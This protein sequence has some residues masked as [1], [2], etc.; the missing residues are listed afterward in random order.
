MSTILLKLAPLFLTPI[1]GFL[2]YYAMQ[3]I[4]DVLKLTAN[5][6]SQ[7]KQAVVVGIGMLLPQLAA[8]TGIALPADPASLLT[9]PGIQGVIAAALA[10]FIKHAQNAGPKAPVSSP[11]EVLASLNAQK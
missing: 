1:A 7:A 4:D 3:L 2:T 9:Q 11:A 6:N 5:W 10:L 8:L